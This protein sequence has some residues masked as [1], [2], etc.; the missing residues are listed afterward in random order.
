MSDGS[1]ERIVR[2]AFERISQ[3]AFPSLQTLLTANSVMEW[4]YAPA[5]LPNRIVGSAAIAT[6][7]GEA[8]PR[9]FCS[10]DFRIDTFY[11]CAPRAVAIVEAHSE[12]VLHDGLLYRNRYVVVIGF[13]NERIALWREYFDPNVAALVTD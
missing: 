2:Q 11:P 7:L 5:L 9:L 1:G 6:A 12:G 13:Q 4:P 10:F 8:M 3:F